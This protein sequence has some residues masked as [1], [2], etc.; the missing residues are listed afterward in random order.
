VKALQHKAA[1]ALTLVFQMRAEPLGETLNC[2]ADVLTQA[3]GVRKTQ[4]YSKMRY[5]FER[6]NGFG[7]AAKRFVKM[8]DKGFA[9]PSRESRAGLTCEISNMTQAQAAQSVHNAGL[10]A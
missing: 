6:G 3:N 7:L 8:F 4:P 2:G 10:K 5:S 1:C 9:K